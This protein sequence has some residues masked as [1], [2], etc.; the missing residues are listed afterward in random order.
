MLEP[1]ELILHGVLPFFIV[2]SEDIDAD[3]AGEIHVSLT[4]LIGNPCAMSGLRHQLQPSVC[5]HNMGVIRREYF[6]TI[7]VCVPWFVV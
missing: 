2:P 3:S 4:V 1:V 7:H 6:V 5:I